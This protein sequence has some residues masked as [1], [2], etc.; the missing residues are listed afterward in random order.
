VPLANKGT[1][2][3]KRDK[4]GGN[5]E[6]APFLPINTAVSLQKYFYFKALICI[7]PQTSA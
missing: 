5:N 1:F 6:H 2:L 7:T 3:S 4:M